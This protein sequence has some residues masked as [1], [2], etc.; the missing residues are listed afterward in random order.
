MDEVGGVYGKLKVTLKR[1]SNHGD[2]TEWRLEVAES[3][4]KVAAPHRIVTLLQLAGWPLQ[5][6]PHSSAV[7]ALVDLLSKAQ[8]SSPCKHTIIMCRCW[9]SLQ[10]TRVF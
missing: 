6:L 9:H 2:I 8:R 4:G 10:I 5:E 3:D 1:L 7:L